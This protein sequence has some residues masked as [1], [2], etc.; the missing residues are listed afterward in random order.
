LVDCMLEEGVLFHCPSRRFLAKLARSF[1]RDF[2]RDDRV[3]CTL[4]S[5]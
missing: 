5:G 4:R 3:I 1:F 2:A